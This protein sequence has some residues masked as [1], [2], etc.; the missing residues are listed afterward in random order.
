MSWV[1]RIEP[2]AVDVREAAARF[3]I[4]DVERLVGDFENLLFR[5]TRPPGR[6]LRLT[7]AS[8]RSVELIEAELE[9]MTHLAAEE[10]SVVAPVRSAQGRLVEQLEVDSA[11]PLLVV[12]MDEAPGSYQCSAQWPE[13]Q[14]IDF[15]GLM[16]SMHR[17]AGTFVAPRSRRPPWSDPMFEVGLA[18]AEVEDPPIYQ[19]SLELFAAV[20]AHPVGASNMLIHYDAHMGNILVSESEGLCLVDFD[21]C[22][23]GT[24]T[25][26]VAIAL[27]HWLFGFAGDLPAEALRFVSLFLHGYNQNASLPRD[28]RDGADRLMSLWELKTVWL[29]ETAPPQELSPREERFM[30][31]RRRRVL[32]GVPYLGAPL[33]EIL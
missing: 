29:I 1:R 13:S 24:P 22:A 14:I 2:T 32:E 16:G 6:I 8:R 7:H 31:G 20:A 18:A 4:A 26:D 5:S 11:D 12:C 17:A 19:R 23:Y 30:V 3:G 15:G 9:F 25:L 28:W 33:A 10:V 21:D 27:F